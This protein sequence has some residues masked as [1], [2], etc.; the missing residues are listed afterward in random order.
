MSDI[1]MDSPL[2]FKIPK[3]LQDLLRLSDQRVTYKDFS[4]GLFKFHKQV[5]NFYDRATQTFD[6]QRYSVFRQYWPSHGRIGCD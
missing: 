5:G 1:T 3:K 2:K 6:L 4:L